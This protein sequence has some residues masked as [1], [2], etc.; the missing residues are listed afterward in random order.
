MEK[1]K[2]GVSLVKYLCPVCGKETDEGIIMNS[3]LT[4]K[5]AKAVEELNGKAIGFADHVCGEC[6]K[7]KDNAVFFIGI[8]ASK[9]QPNNP[10]RTGQLVAVRKD[11]D[12][13]EH[14]AKYIL[15][16]RDHAKYCFIEEDAGK[17]IGLW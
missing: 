14:L 1:N 13:V 5:N 9:S 7:Y 2:L 15:E 10:Y 4:E 11:S 8:D 6:T 3:L 17:K 12:L 16:L